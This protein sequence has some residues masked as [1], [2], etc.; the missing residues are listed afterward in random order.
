M[1]SRKKRENGSISDDHRYPIKIN[2]D[3]P[4][5]NLINCIQEIKFSLAE[6]ENASQTKEILIDKSVLIDEGQDLSNFDWM[7]N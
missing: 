2:S 7:F 3:D 5:S 6:N 1:K 4:N